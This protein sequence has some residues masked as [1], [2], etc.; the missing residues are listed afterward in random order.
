MYLSDSPDAQSLPLG[1][2]FLL[3]SALRL[4]LPLI[5]TWLRKVKT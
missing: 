3:P 1:A 4:E 5:L 2:Y